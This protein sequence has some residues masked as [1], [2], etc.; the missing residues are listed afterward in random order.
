[1]EVHLASVVSRVLGSELRCREAEEREAAALAR[2][3][4]LEGQLADTE[5]RLQTAEDLLD[6]SSQEI[7][8]ILDTVS[9]VR[10][11]GI[12]RVETGQVNASGETPRTNLIDVIFNNIHD[13]GNDILAYFAEYDSD[14][15]EDADDMEGSESESEPQVFEG[16]GPDLRGLFVGAPQGWPP[17]QA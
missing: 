1:M 7:Q 13:L 3:A 14:A 9:E 8:K 4:E 5:E 17:A 10:Q 6:D 15:M 2:V 11:N 16:P 12:I